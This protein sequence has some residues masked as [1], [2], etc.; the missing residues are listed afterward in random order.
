MGDG[1]LADGDLET[2]LFILDGKVSMTGAM[3]VFSIWIMH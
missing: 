2:D 1:D 3:T